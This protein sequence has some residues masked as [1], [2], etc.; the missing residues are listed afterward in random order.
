MQYS[1]RPEPLMSETIEGMIEAYNATPLNFESP[2]DSVV[3][4][5]IQL[6]DNQMRVDE[7]NEK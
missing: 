4:K 6:V 7:E 2:S 5:M 3:E 1:K